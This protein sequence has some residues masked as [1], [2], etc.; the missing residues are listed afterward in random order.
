M[1]AA[2]VALRATRRWALLLAGVLM[3]LPIAAVAD[4]ARE[5]LERVNRALA[6]Q[7]Y[8]GTFFHDRGGQS[9]SLRIHHRVKNGEVAE[10]LVSLD[11]SRR[12]FIRLGE[13]LSYVLPDQRTVIIERRPRQGGLLPNFPRFDER[14]ARFYRLDNVQ[15]TRLIE[16]DARLISLVP[17]DPYRYGYRVWIDARTRL[18]LKSEVYDRGG[19]VLERIAF[20]NLQL[21]ADIPDATFRPAVST[22]GFR[23]IEND[24]GV[25]LRTVNDSASVWSLRT[26]PR[27][28][29][30]TQRG[31]QTLPGT[32]DPVSHIVLSDGLASVSVFI[33]AR[34]PPRSAKE[35][36]LE[37]QIGAST[38]FST[39]L[40][41][42]HVVVIGEI[43]VQTARLI[44]SELAPGEPGVPA[45][46]AEPA[47]PGVPGRPR[48]AVGVVQPRPA[49]VPQAP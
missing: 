20:A 13:E 19:Q 14:T 34:L 5:W 49:F 35:I 7:S 41:G 30:V 25:R 43:P 42:H 11:G 38:A 6:E 33:G 46:P 32:D 37:R 8:E 18:P 27:G 1:T 16:R 36:A 3:T 2:G 15:R 22:D 28:F 31:E 12:E 40:H 47:R 23:R 21:V 26:A 45:R 48:E 24:G 10:R 9:E 29:Q 4:D 17:L 44:A 39:F